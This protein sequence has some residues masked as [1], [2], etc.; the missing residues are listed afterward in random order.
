MEGV[1]RSFDDKDTSEVLASIL[2]YIHLKQDDAIAFARARGLFA[3]YRGW[4]GTITILQWLISN[5]EQLPLSED[6]KNYL[7][8]KYEARWLCDFYTNADKELSQLIDDYNSKGKMGIGPALLSITEWS[9]LYRSECW[10]LWESFAIEG[11]GQFDCDEYFTVEALATAVSY[12]ISLCYSNNNSTGVDNR[13]VWDDTED[14]DTIYNIISIAVKRVTVADWEFDVDYLDY[15]LNAIDESETQI[16]DKNSYEKSIR[17]GYIKNE[18]KRNALQTSFSVMGKGMPS[19]Q[20]YIRAHFPK[21]RDKFIPI[22]YKD[23]GSFHLYIVKDSLIK[24]FYPINYGETR[25]FWEEYIDVQTVADELSLSYNEVMIYKITENCCVRDIILF[26]RF[27]GYI[28][29]FRH[30]FINEESVDGNSII[31]P[32]LM[33]IKKDELVGALRPFIGDNQKTEELIDFY[34]WNRQGRLDLQYTPI[35]QVSDDMCLLVPAVLFNSNL[36]R[37]GIVNGR[38]NNLQITNANGNLEPL[39]RYAKELFDS[40]KNIFNNRTSRQYHYNNDRGEI[41]LVVWTENNLY[42]IECKNPITPTSSSEIRTTFDYIKKA[43]KQLDCALE[44]LKNKRS[45]L[46]DWGIPLREY[47][48]HT[49]ILLGNRLFTTTANGFRHP[50]RYI[51]ELNMLFN[52]GRILSSFGTWR[53]WG[54][55]CFSED[56]FLKFISNNELLSKNYI[57]AMGPFYI[58]VQF[59]DRVLKRQYYVMDLFKFYELNDRE[60]NNEST[61]EQIAFRK[62]EKAKHDE[63]LKEFEE[64]IKQFSE[65]HQS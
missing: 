64:I 62:E 33:P 11:K 45:I 5:I 28:T 51:N 23:I 60:F 50:V 26:K 59:G 21:N 7:S 43:E 56:D 55:D 19:I 2:I 35:I 14:K 24:I 10:K 6:T 17:L 52:G 63:Q 15:E 42:L 49:L 27:F 4:E 54:G 46:R 29:Y 41:D 1:I 61:K 38:K 25:L 13:V 22:S 57:E 8:C 58:S 36:I 3:Y 40:K 18:F 44:L 12:I 47:Q 31:K 65:N 30:E 9:F 34:S 16:I 48:L 53:Y 37:N 32:V 20:E 39:E